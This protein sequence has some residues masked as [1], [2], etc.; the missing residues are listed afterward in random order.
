MLITDQG[1]IIRTP[2]QDISELS[3]TAAGVIVIRLEAGQKLVN[4]TKID[5]GDEESKN[6]E[7]GV[8]A[9]DGADGSGAEASDAPDTDA[10]E[11][12]DGTEDADVAEDA[13]LLPEDYTEPGDGQE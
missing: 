12:T 8:P 7:K 2:A 4:L 5:R 13:V 3:R 9:D 6:G 1:I 10:A 11:E